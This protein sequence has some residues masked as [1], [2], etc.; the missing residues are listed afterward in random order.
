MKRILYSNGSFVT[1]DRIVDAVF[2][3]A[4]ALARAGV[5][6]HLRVPGLGPDDTVRDYDLVIG[7][8]SQLMAEPAETVVDEVAGDEFV[9]DVLERTRRAETGRSE[10]MWHGN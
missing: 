6:D 7:P 1:G 2:D 10:R 4:A 3:Y 8:A 9:E 5:A